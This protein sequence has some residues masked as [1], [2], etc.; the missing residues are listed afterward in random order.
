MLGMASVISR[1]STRLLALAPN[2]IEASALIAIAIASRLL[3]HPI[4]GRSTHA[5]VH[6][7]L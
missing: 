3:H 7:S 4:F 1:T 6:S 2:Y 5:S